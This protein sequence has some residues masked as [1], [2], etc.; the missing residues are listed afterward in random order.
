VFILIVVYRFPVGAAVFIIYLFFIS[1]LPE[2]QCLFFIYCLS[3]S[4]MS[5]SVYSL[6][7][8][9]LSPTGANNIRLIKSH[10]V[11]LSLQFIAAVCLSL[12]YSLS[13]SCRISS[14]YH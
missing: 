1:L 2:Q 12:N 3:F 13:F 7:I 10:V 9:Y 5:S 14:V 11:C 6:F 8:V 4:Y